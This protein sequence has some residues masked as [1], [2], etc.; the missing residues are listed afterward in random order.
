MSD[1]LTHARASHE[2]ALQQLM[3][4]AAIPSVGTDP[5]HA[6]DTLRAARW[7][8]DEMHAIGL[9]EVALLPTAG[10]PV[11]YGEWLGAGADAPTVLL[12]A[13]YDVQPASAR[14]VGTA[15][16]SRHSCAM[17]VSM[18]GASR[19]TKATAS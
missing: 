8:A 1:A 12:Y 6:Q 16:H 11:V 3:E 13:H 2:L 18:G 14:M 15:S 9:Q 4:L 10:N 17:A 5:A 7:L 19:M